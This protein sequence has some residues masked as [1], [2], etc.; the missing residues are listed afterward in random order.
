MPRSKG[1]TWLLVSFLISA[2]AKGHHATSMFDMRTAQLTLEGRVVE[3]EWENP[4]VYLHIE[5]A[6]SPAVRWAL[7]GNNVVQ[8]EAQCWKKD[9]LRPGDRVVAMANP[10]RDPAKR[11]GHLMSLH[12]DGR[13]LWGEDSSCVEDLVFGRSEEMDGVWSLEPSA[14]VFE[15]GAGHTPY[16]GRGIPPLPLTRA[17]TNAIQLY[18]DELAASL[19]CSPVLPPLSLI[20][21]GPIAIE[22]D[23]EAMLIREANF[24]TVRIVDLRIDSHDGADETPLG[25]SIGAWDG[26]TLDVGTARF[27]EH[28]A[29]NWRAPPFWLPSSA[30][31]YLQESFA[32]TESGQVLVYRFEFGD[33]VFLAEPVRGER[34]FRHTPGVEFEPVPCSADNARRFLF[35]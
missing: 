21:G 7:E 26:D 25:H 15:G 34:R 29:G 19:A 1:R 3:V 35:E 12:K 28:P 20:A 2:A 31:R 22:V 13:A 27:A 9:S 10:S 14:L 11:V 23:E 16:D 33:P 5:T 4:H 17:G 8:T 30:E 32:L 18:T 24:A 6:D